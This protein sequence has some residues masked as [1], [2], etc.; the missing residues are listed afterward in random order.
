MFAC[1]LGAEGLITVAATDDAAGGIVHITLFGFRGRGRRRGL[2]VRGDVVDGKG[3]VLL[4][5]TTFISLVVLL[6]MSLPLVALLLLVAITLIVSALLGLLILPALPIRV[7]L[8]VL[9]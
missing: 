1:H 2:W 4:F 8:K 6:L 5:L 7:R 9:R 3:L